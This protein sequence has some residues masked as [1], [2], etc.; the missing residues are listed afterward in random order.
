MSACGA[1][2]AHLHIRKSITRD[3]KCRVLDIAGECVKAKLSA[4]QPV[5]ATHLS[6]Y[7]SNLAKGSCL[8]ISFKIIPVFKAISG[9]PYL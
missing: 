2:Y 7:N 1:P 9:F 5:T 8:S 4:R 3:A 6:E